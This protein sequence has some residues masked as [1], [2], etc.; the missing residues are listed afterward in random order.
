MD[1]DAGNQKQLHHH[2]HHQVSKGC[3]KFIK[4]LL[5]SLFFYKKPLEKRLT[6]G[7]NFKSHGVFVENE[8]K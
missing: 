7:C 1:A 4:R 5:L 8:S 6:K 3:S 2:H